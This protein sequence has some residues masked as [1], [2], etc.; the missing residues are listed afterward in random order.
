MT[1]SNL[2]AAMLA[3][4][5]TALGCSSGN[6]VAPPAE[7]GSGGGGGGGGGGGSITYTVTVSAA[8]SE[9]LAGGSEPATLTV[10][11]R[12][13]DTGQAPADGT[14]VVVTT[15]QG[16]LGVNEAASPVQTMSLQIAAGQAQT[17]FF[18]PAR[19]TTAN[20]LAQVGQ[21]V[22]S[23][24]VPIVSTLPNTFYLTAVSPN[25]GNPD[26]G[27][28]VTIRGAGF[29]E[30]LRVLFGAVVARVVD[31]PGATAIVVDTP[32]SAQPV[33]EGSSLVVDVTVTND[34]TAAMPA[35]DTLAGAFTY[36]AG[37]PES[38]PPFY[39]T[40]VQPNS[41]S[42]DGG[43][44]VAVLGAGFRQ[45]LQVQMGGRTA[46]VTAV[47]STRISV[48]T[49]ASAQPVAAGATLAVDV[50]VTNGLDDATPASATLPGGFIY[51][52]GAAPEPV[53]VTALSPSSGPYTGG[54]VVTVTGSGFASPV[55]VELA[56]VRQEDETVV[57]ATEVQFTTAAVSVTMCPAGGALPVMGLTVTDLGSG[58]AGTA[59]LTFTYEVP[60]PLVSRI[61]PTAGPQ[62]G[63]TLVSIEGE[64]FEAPARVVFAR[65][66]D[67]YAGVVQSVAS[68]LVTVSSPSVPDTFFPE[69][70][71]VTT[72]G[73]AGKRY[74]PVTADLAITDQ[75]T[76][77]ADT[78]PNAYTYQPTFPQCRVVTPP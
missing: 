10:T 21:S 55:A 16:S 49:P 53:V 50:T 23:L 47:T 66:G 20:L 8:P 30:P 62:L 28:L 40:Q 70:D 36:Q 76:G 6:P 4:S 69:V 1:R 41:G 13:T 14:A 63:N 27:D 22:G 2:L 72:D 37:A 61:S 64:G 26:G 71:C 35:T 68:T 39:L 3:L 75:S 57:S 56:G 58:T 17:S 67:S 52:G 19:V 78:F 12:R 34:L 24:A 45:P 43:E 46:Q 38:P 51:D 44:A 18:P 74:V 25:V 15:D 48:V 77:C 60:L 9:L 11:A 5:L 65:G 32:A 7:G 42:P 33:A 73:D 54:T 29:T 59:A 31:V